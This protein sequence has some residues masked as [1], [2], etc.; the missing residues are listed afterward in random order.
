[1][2]HFAA[3][4]K[5]CVSFMYSLVTTNDWFDVGRVTIEVLPNEVLID[6]IYCYV[7]QVRERDGL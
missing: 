3:S 5:Q 7:V 2:V 4:P 6:V 1:M